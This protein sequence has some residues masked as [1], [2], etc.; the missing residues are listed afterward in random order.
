[1][2]PVTLL[3]GLNLLVLWLGGGMHL[4]NDTGLWDRTLIL[5]GVFNTFL[6]LLA[7]IEIFRGAVDE[8]P[9][10]D[11][12]IEGVIKQWIIIISIPAVLMILSLASPDNVIKPPRSVEDYIKGDI[13]PERVFLGFDTYQLD[14][15]VYYS[16]NNFEKQSAVTSVLMRVNATMIR[17]NELFTNSTHIQLCLYLDK[18]RQYH[19]YSW[20]TYD[21]KYQYDKAW[22]EDTYY[23]Y[24]DTL[25]QDP[26]GYKCLEIC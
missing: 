17:G 26:K 22:C 20:K 21:K 19:A 3:M 9:E 7:I 5:P 1:M 4:I 14:E 2:N 18:E 12:Q 16:V 15:L 13:N 11:T 6:L 10:K 23:V 24:M 25:I 8:R